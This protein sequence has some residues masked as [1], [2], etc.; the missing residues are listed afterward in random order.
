MYVCLCIL[1]YFPT[2]NYLCQPCLI[3][4]NY[5]SFIVIRFANS[6][7]FYEN[8]LSSCLILITPFI[9]CFTACRCCYRALYRLMMSNKAGC[10]LR[11]FQLCLFLLISFTLVYL[12]FDGY[13][14]YKIPSRLLP[15]KIERDRNHD[16]SLWPA[17][18]HLNNNAVSILTLFIYY[19]CPII[20]ITLD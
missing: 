17:Y 16:Y 3:F 19:C 8:E 4:L 6:R 20:L 5:F 2:S 15:R 18:R 7:L 10:I 11:P 14:V 13:S 12:V 9:F 1:F